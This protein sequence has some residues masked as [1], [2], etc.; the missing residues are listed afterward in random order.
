MKYNLTNRNYSK[1]YHLIVNAQYALLPNE[2]DL[3]LTMLTEIKKRMKILKYI[4]LLKQ[5]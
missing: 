5:N 3:V 1:Q 4:V 2:I